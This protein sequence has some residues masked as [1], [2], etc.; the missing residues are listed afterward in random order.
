MSRIKHATLGLTFVTCL[1]FV[2]SYAREIIIAMQFGTGTTTDAFV[3]AYGF[4]T[5]VGEITFGAMLAAS[6][7]PAFTSLSERNGDQWQ[8]VVGA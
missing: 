2:A 7:V 5:T 1:N 8:R 4:V 3:A 6:I